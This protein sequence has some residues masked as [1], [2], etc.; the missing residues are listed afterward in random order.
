MITQPAATGISLYR[1]TLLCKGTTLNV[2]A[3]AG[4]PATYTWTSTNGFTSSNAAISVTTPGTYKVTVNQTGNC[5]YIDSIKLRNTAL[6]AIPAKMVLASHAFVGETIVAV[7][8]TDQPQSQ[9][10][11]IPAGAQVISES[12]EKLVMKF[13]V[14]GQYEVKL[15]AKS[16]DV[17]SSRDSATVL[18][19][20][21]TT[22]IG[23]V[24]EITVREVIAAPNPTTG[25]F[26]LSI[27]LNQAGK[28]AVRIY[29]VT[30]LLAYSKL[31]PDNG[32]TTIV[33]PVNLAGQNKGTYIIVVETDNSNEVR[34]LILN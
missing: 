6:E 9:A 15:G 26:N 21:A 32:S 4:V 10:W 16:Y 24:R 28:V 31:I 11:I 7:N 23:N 5:T 8:L 34:K 20:P 30:G 27:K 19:Q 17:C 12:T 25:Q 18:I 2:T 22:D 13:P 33:E 14:R 3:S 29:S 1:D